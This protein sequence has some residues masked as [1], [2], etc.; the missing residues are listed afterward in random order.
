[1]DELDKNTEQLNSGL[2]LL[3]KSSLVIFLFLFL[4]KALYY[5]YRLII[6]R[7]FGPEI[8]GLFSIALIILSVFVALFSLGLDQGLLRFIPLYDV[9]NKQKEIR[10]LFGFSVKLTF[11]LS[12]SAAIIL[13]FSSTFISI[14]I[15]HNEDLIIFL[16]IFSLVIPVYLFS[17]LFLSILR[18]YEKVIWYS[19][20]L[21]VLQNILKVIAIVLLFFIGFNSNAIILSY[22]LG[23]LG[24]FLLSFYLIRF[25]FK[26]IFKPSKLGKNERIKIRKEFFSYSWPLMF[27]GILSIVNW[28]TDSFMIG[29]F[30][31][32]VEVG[33]YNVAFPIVYLMG[34]V[35]EIFMQ[36]FF[37]LITKEFSKKNLFLVKQIS[38]QVGKW[39]FVLNLPFLIIFFLFPGAI[40]NLLFGSSYLAAE[41]ALRILSVGFFLGTITIPVTS[42]LLYIQGKS[43]LLLINLIIIFLTNLILNIFLVP[44]YG[45][46]GA[47]FST[48]LSTILFGII[49]IFELNHYQ[50]II[51]FRRKI[52]RIILV[53]LIPTVLLL[54]L[55]KIIAINSLSLILLGVFFG[56]TYILAMLTTNCLDRNDF[57]IIKTVFK[58]LRKK[59]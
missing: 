28:W 13:F 22:F 27:S 6:A 40:I 38:Q 8:Y 23:I 4:S 58:K 51:P 32:A 10:D 12:L 55:R 45:I 29:F 56:L 46:S 25:Y 36:L 50:S 20:I 7:W 49:L 37:P 48:T 2:K 1:M 24:M 44:K 21:N 11:F 35:P 41:N 14:N 17:N 9:K 47:A 31:N 16:K 39:I 52:F 54:I 3:A 33:F 26:D 43:K 42:N 57:M 18:A 53:S 30:R 34:I 5:I 59:T 19:F 15:F